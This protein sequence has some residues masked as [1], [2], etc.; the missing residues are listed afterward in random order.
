MDIKENE[1]KRE[2]FR[3]LVEYRT[4]LVIERLRVLGN[5][6]NTITYDY[7]DE[8]V[9]KVFSAIEKE[10]SKVKAKFR[11]SKEKEKFTL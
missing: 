7:T 8:E 6:A 10:V 4:N 9:D 1:T 3:R 11:I 2:R 5:C